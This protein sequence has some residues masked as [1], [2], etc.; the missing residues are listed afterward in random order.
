MW[1]LH[2]ALKK[3]VHLCHVSIEQILITFINDLLLLSH[4][5]RNS[6]WLSELQCLLRF[7]VEAEFQLAN[8]KGLTNFKFVS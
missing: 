2:A 5:G 7:A 3:D 4:D 8:C 6:G 1:A